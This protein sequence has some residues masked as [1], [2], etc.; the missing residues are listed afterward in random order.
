[1]NPWPLY[2]APFGAGSPPR[3]P[4]PVRADS[5][6]HG[7]YLGCFGVVSRCYRVV[8]GLFHAVILQKVQSAEA[9]DISTANGLSF[10]VNLKKEVN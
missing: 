2:G 6:F 4:F 9:I 10:I 8:S 3:V 7:L 1:M 5:F